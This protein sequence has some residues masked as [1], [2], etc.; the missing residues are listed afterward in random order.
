[1][2]LVFGGPHPFS[3]GVVLAHIGTG[4]RS[5]VVLSAAEVIDI[6]TRVCHTTVSVGQRAL[7]WPSVA[8]WYAP[9]GDSGE[10]DVPGHLYPFDKLGRQPRSG[11]EAVVLAGLS[12]LSEVP[13][14]F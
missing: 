1:M 3:E 4:F 10:V 9:E 14:A 13:L 11:S 5:A 6:R 12:L 2:R 8:Y 7:A